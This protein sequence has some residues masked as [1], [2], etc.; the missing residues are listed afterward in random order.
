MGAADVNK[1]TWNNL[2]PRKVN[3]FV[4]RALNGRLVRVE[5]DKKRAKGVVGCWLGAKLWLQFW[6]WL[7]TPLNS[8][9][10][11]NLVPN[12]IF[13]NFFS[14]ARAYGTTTPSALM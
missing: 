7:T 6:L 3:V 10:I 13:L 4:W 2:V 9:A 5:L 1:T 12:S 11:P 8:G 14:M